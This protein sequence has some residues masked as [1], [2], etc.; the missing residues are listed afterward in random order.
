MLASSATTVPLQSEL[1]VRSS[2]NSALRSAESLSDGVGSSA[3]C[4]VMTE[5]PGKHLGRLRSHRLSLWAW[6]SGIALSLE[7]DMLARPRHV[8][9]ASH[10]AWRV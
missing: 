4:V 7:A 10:R 8:Y 5:G 2:R 3:S 9:Q 6:Q 1:F